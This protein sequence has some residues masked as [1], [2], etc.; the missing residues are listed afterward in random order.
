MRMRTAI[1]MQYVG[2]RGLWACD[3]PRQECK[4]HLGRDGCD[5]AVK[6]TIQRREEN[7]ISTR[8]SLH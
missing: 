2:G 8:P 3:V 7:N 5:R 4:M 1:H 6:L